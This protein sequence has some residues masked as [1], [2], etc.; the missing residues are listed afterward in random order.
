[1][2]Q[3]P[4]LQDVLS[5]TTGDRSDPVRMIQSHLGD[6][7]SALVMHLLSGGMLRDAQL[8]RLISLVSA[9]RQARGLASAH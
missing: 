2:R 4:S 8:R 6:R 5:V 3:Q 1:M 9:E 7:W